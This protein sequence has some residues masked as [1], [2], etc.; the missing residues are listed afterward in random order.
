MNAPLMTNRENFQDKEKL[1]DYLAH[2]LRGG[3]LAIVL[4]S[5]VSYH[6]GLP[7]WEELVHGLYRHKKKSLPKG[8]YSLEDLAEN[9]KNSYYQKD[10][11]GFLD[12][13]YAV[14]YKK[15]SFGFEKFRQHS[16]LAAIASLVMASQRRSSSN[17]ITFN[18]DNLLELYLS[19]HGL[20]VRSIFRD[21]Y[22]SSYGDVTVY[23]P[24]G[25][26]PFE[27]SADRSSEIVFDQKSYSVISS[28]KG[29]LRRR[30][31]LNTMLHKTC[32]F[33]GLSGKDINFDRLLI[34]SVDNH[35]CKKDNTVFWGV[36]FSNKNDRIAKKRWEARGIFYKTVKDFDKDLPKF[37]F[38]ICEE[39][40]KL[41][42]KD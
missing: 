31:I 28:T 32:L 34:D 37:L 30:I 27:L 14:L 35:A 40:A 8:D 15:A 25:F 3:R 24:H 33:I 19:Y 39:A 41:E 38:G 12:A 7:T 13:V 26:I 6:F 36:T 18:F 9:F 17:V 10:T 2:Q 16:L 4:G 42:I 22:W 1:Q 23:H 5:G 20:V 29:G 21:Q 11:N